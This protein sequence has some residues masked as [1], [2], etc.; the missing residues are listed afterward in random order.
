LKHLTAVGKAVCKVLLLRLAILLCPYW[1][2]AFYPF[3]Y[4]LWAL[5]SCIN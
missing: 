3:F 2:A 1:W 4:Y 5:L